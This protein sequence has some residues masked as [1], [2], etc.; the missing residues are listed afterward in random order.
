MNNQTQ[1]P[2]G[3]RVEVYAYPVLFYKFLS[4]NDKPNNCINTGYHKTINQIPGSSRNYPPHQEPKN[5]YES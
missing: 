3:R 4:D 5:I 1:P 2:Q